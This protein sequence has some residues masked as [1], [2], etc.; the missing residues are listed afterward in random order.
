M[1]IGRSINKKADPLSQANWLFHKE[2]DLTF[3]RL[4]PSLTLGAG[5]SGGWL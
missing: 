4:D 5:T 3:R 1:R 2:D